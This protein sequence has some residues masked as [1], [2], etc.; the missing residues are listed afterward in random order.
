VNSFVMGDETPL[1]NAARAGNI[2]VV[3]NLVTRGADVNNA[4]PAQEGPFGEVRSP[5]SEARRFDRRAVVERLVA[6]GA[7]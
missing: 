7:R 2:D 1:I 3:N 6:L 4:V 5:L